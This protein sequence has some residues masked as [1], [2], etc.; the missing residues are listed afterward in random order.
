MTTA[1]EV[2]V[3]GAAELAYRTPGS[4]SLALAGQ[5]LIW[6]VVLVLASRAGVP[7][8]LRRTRA[9]DETLLD[10]DREVGAPLP[11]LEESGLGGWVEEL[12]ERP[13]SGR[14]DEVTP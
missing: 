9:R 3:G 6:V 8:R 2:P 10:L 5:A 1:Y 13:N 4:R 7:K 14:R 11:D 12:L